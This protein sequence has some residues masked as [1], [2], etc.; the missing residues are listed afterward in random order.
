M[1]NDFLEMPVA[2]VRDDT[3]NAFSCT[4]SGVPR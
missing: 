1:V 3:S 4:L 2:E